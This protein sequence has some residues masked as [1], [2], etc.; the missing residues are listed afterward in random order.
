MPISLSEAKRMIWNAISKRPPERNCIEYRCKEEDFDVLYA[1]TQIPQIKQKMKTDGFEIRIVPSSEENIDFQREYMV[2]QYSSVMAARLLSNYTDLTVDRWLRR[3]YTHSYNALNFCEADVSRVISQVFPVELLN[4]D[5]IADQLAEKKETDKT[6]S[7]L[8]DLIRSDAEKVTTKELGE[9]FDK[10]VD[11]HT[12][13]GIVVDVLPGFI[14]VGLIQLALRHPNLEQEMIKSG[15][16][17]ALQL[18]DGISDVV[19]EAR[20][21]LEMGWHTEFDRG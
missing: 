19:P 13:I 4:Y 11:C 10:L 21:Y 18:I 5:P 14:L 7:M 3:L 17:I 9:L 1:A 2:A 8:L 20:K 15:K 16:D 6:Q 12:P